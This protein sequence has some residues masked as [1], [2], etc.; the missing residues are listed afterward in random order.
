[1]CELSN[2]MAGERH[3]RGMLCVN[4][5]LQSTGLQQNPLDRRLCG[6]QERPQRERKEHFAG[7]KF[8]SNAPGIKLA[9]ELIFKI[10]SS[11]EQTGSSDK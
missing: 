6:L 1:M 11:T 5:P 3:G 2:G 4:R 7:G 10:T 8:L 9:W